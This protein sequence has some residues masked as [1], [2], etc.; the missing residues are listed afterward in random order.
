MKKKSSHGQYNDKNH[1]VLETQKNG[2]RAAALEKSVQTICEPVLIQPLLSYILF[3]MQ[4]GVAENIKNAVLGHFDAKDLSDAKCAL[5]D[6]CDCSII[7]DKK[8][9][10]TLPNQMEVR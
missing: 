8:A 7:G 2:E 10:K 6:H 4:S 5:R 3:S 1:N 9:E